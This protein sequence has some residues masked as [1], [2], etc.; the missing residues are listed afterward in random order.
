MNGGFEAL[1]DFQS[2][3]LQ[4]AGK[5]GRLRF[6]LSAAVF[7]NVRLHRGHVEREM[8]ACHWLSDP[9]VRHCL[10]GPGFLCGSETSTLP[11]HEQM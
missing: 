8:G 6:S 5:S 7:K 10:I 3:C 4:S 9:K 2:S 11:Y 1:A